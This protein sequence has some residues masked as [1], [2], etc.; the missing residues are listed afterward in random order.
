MKSHD[1]D[2]VDED[3]ALD[4]VGADNYVFYA[5][6]LGLIGLALA[7]GG[8]FACQVRLYTVDPG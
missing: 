2:A 1:F 5:N 6:S 7:L 3:L 8:Y 4:G